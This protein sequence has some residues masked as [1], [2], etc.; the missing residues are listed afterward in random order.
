MHTLVNKV[1]MDNFI[2]FTRWV[3]L[4]TEANKIT[5]NIFYFILFNST[6]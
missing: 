4:T 6:K 1:S 5:L 3:N 2:H